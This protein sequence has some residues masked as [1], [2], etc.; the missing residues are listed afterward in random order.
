MRLTSCAFNR[1]VSA[2]GMPI[3]AKILPLLTSC[4]GS[5]CTIALSLLFEGRF[6]NDL[7][8]PQAP[9]DHFD[10]RLRRF[11]ALLRFLLKGMQHI[12]NPRKAHG[13]DS[14]VSV[15]LMSFHHLQHATTAKSLQGL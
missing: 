11:D 4:S 6:M 7:G 1:C 14:P 9:P 10:I 2:S 3:S 5:F 12:E 13:V 15:A 8:F